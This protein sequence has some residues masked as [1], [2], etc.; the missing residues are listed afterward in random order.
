MR[1]RVSDSDRPGERAWPKVRTAADVVKDSRA[2]CSVPPRMYYLASTPR[3]SAH[4][5]NT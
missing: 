3:L 2:A 1:E 4:T 5:D